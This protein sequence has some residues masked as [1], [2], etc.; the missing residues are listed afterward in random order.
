MALPEH[1]WAREGLDDRE[2]QKP[3]GGEGRGADVCVGRGVGLRGL[4]WE[5]DSIVLK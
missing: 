3:F 1:T 2:N 4:K 5:E